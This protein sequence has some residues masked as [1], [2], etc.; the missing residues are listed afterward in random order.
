MPTCPSCKTEHKKSKQGRC[1]NCKKAVTV[2]KG[3]WFIDGS[4]VDNFITYFEER[5]S[6]KL[7][8]QN[9]TNVCFK[10]QR[11]LPSWKI[12]YATAQRLLAQL[13]WDVDLA[14]EVIDI[15]FTDKQFSFKLY[16]SITYA[17]KDF[18]PATII[19]NAKREAKNNRVTTAIQ[20]IENVME[21]EDIF[22]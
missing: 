15:L 10:F 20:N 9:Q 8:L 22:L 4:P 18:H 14:K 1:P 12:E 11:K 17:I 5:L 3:M 21:K 16:G 13:D 19:A 6:K 7:S 2:Y